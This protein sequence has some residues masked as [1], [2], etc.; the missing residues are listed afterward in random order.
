MHIH[1]GVRVHTMPYKNG[2][3]YAEIVPAGQPWYRRLLPGVG[4]WWFE[5]TSLEEGEIPTHH[6]TLD[7]GAYTFRGAVAKA[8]D[9]VEAEYQKE[10]K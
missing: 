8:I 4:N 6:W 5:I 9:A 3:I 2:I 10:L 1:E 7:G